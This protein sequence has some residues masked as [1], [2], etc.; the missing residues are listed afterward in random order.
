VLFVFASFISLL[1]F[2]LSNH[3]EGATESRTDYNGDD[4]VARILGSIVFDS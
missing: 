1:R 4:V 2:S 3:P